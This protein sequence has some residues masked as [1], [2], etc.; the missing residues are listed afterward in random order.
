MV[1]A[2]KVPM[3]LELGNNEADALLMRAI[4]GV[5]AVALVMLTSTLATAE[6]DNNA[7]DEDGRGDCVTAEETIIAVS[8]MSCDMLDVK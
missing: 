3:K 1:E 2:V 7:D 8:V 5:E 4:S 6:E